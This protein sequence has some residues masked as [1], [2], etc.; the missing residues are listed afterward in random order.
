MSKY[1]YTDKESQDTPIGSANP[2]G[3][4]QPDIRQFGAL[5]REIS[6]QEVTD[7]ESGGRRHLHPVALTKVQK[8]VQESE[9]VRRIVPNPLRM[10]SYSQIIMATNIPQKALDQNLSR[11]RFIIAQANQSI[12][13][14]WFY[15]PQNI[16]TPGGII[17]NS[18]VS[19]VNAIFDENNVNISTDEI[20]IAGTIGDG[21]TVYEGI[22]VS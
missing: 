19:G 22:D 10:V 16:S 6:R 4:G 15:R 5:R 18:N 21:V 12:T 8:R 11:R 14:F 1:G 20:W 2:F 3:K 9:N 13:T 7:P 17:L